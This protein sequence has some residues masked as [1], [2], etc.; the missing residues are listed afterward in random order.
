MKLKKY[1]W[2]DITIL[3][4]SII[5]A[6]ISWITVLDIFKKTVLSMLALLM[7][8]IVARTMEIDV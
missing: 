5:F 7:F 3:L 1:F 2:I 8:V 4:L 6:L